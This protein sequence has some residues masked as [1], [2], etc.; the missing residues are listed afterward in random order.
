MT[1]QNVKVFD[2][3]SVI[4]HF[5]FYFLRFGRI[6]LGFRAWDLGFREHYPFDLVIVLEDG[7]NVVLVS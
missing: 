1:T 4:L 3:S 2:F 5:Y 6:C 7:N